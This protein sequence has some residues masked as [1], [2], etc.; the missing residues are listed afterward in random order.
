MK[1]P[2]SLLHVCHQP[3]DFLST[4]IH[5]ELQYNLYSENTQGK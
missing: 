1:N 4:F 3:Y 2:K 5:E